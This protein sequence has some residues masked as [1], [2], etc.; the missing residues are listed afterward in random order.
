MP[1]HRGPR[2][3]GAAASASASTTSDTP[4][5]R[6]YF[7]SDLAGALEPCGCTKDQLGGLDHAA[8]WMRAQ[9]AKAP[10]AILVSAG[11]LFFMEPS[12]KSDHRDQDV[13]KAET[14]AASLKTLGLAAFTP[15]ANEWA[16][17]ERSSRT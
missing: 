9:K 4:T 2:S 1:D 17:G 10:N 16:E 7:V 5:V 11:P 13:A 3:G 15:G 8:A 14:I 12:L 6:L